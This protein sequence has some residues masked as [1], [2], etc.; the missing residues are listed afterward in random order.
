[1]RIIDYLCDKCIPHNVITTLGEDPEKTTADPCLRTI[2]FLRDSESLDKSKELSGFNIGIF[3][4]AGY[5]TVGSKYRFSCSPR[6]RFSHIPGCVIF[7]FS[8]GVF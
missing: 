3:E 4:L 7:S 5:V 8:Q 1:M 2:V 6:I